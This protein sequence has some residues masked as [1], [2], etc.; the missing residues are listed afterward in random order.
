VALVTI[1]GGYTLYSRFMAPSSPEPTQIEVPVQR[2][3]LSS[4]VSASGNI[5]MPH[6]AR[7]S[8]DTSGTV[9]SVTVDV[10]DMVE[11][12][13]VLAQ[14]DPTPLERAVTQARAN[15]NSSYINLNKVRNAYDASDIADAEAAVRNAQVALEAAR[16]DLAITKSSE[17]YAK[18]VRT[19]Q[20]EANWYDTDCGDAIIAYEAS[21]IS[22]DERIRRCNNA[23][24]ARERLRVAQERAANALITSE[25]NVSKA[26]DT[27]R[28]AEETLADMLDGADPDDVNLKW[29]Q[30]VSAQASY[31]NAVDNLAHATLTATFPA[32]VAAVNIGEGDR[33]LASSVA[34]NLVYTSQVELGATLDE[35]DTPLVRR[36]QRAIVT[37][38]ALPDLELE[39]TV[40]SISPL[41]T[42]QS[43]V[44]N[45][46]V[47]LEL[48]PDDEVTLLEGMTVLAEIITS[49][50]TNVL[51]V[52][53]RAVQSQDGR[54]M[55]LVKTDE[56]VQPRPVT[57]GMSDG[58]LTEIVSGL[59]EG[60]LVVI[61]TGTATGR[62]PGFGI[63]RSLGGGGR[64]P[65]P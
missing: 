45:Y 23:A 38:D 13:Q 60:E 19:A 46:E 51:L 64:P 31:E 27:L 36:G 35:L 42:I 63:Q 34:M 12:G 17:T 16:R 15:L 30:V 61:S 32:E 49:E 4:T 58:E 11:A 14:L 59:K 55:V 28:R 62:I 22:E 48:S 50:Q 44:V 41:A 6:Q 52:P 10:G 53:S 65:G 43:G 47:T 24:N 25:N 56:G 37:L 5:V 21:S 29:N 7:L 20:Y 1:G 40:V 26:E 57:I 2:G 39:A 33:V 18:E 9:V 54:R 3:D 8:F